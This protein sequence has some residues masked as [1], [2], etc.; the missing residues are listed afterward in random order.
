MEHLPRPLGRAVLAMHVD[1]MYVEREA[2]LYSKTT[3]LGLRMASHLETGCGA[4]TTSSIGPRLEYHIRSYKSAGFEVG[5]LLSDREGG[6]LVSTSTI[7]SKSIIVNPPS[8]GKHDPVIEKNIKTL[9]SRACTNI[10]ALPFH[11][12]RQLLIWLVL[13]CVSHLNMEPIHIMCVTT[14]AENEALFSKRE[15]GDV[16]KAR[17]LSRKLHFP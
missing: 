11:L 2:F 12:C 13:C 7:Q 1:L 8:A 17:D 6:A 3:P 15:V 10:H 5:T 4:R 14:V 9:K 16:R